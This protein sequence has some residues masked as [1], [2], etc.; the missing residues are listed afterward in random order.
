MKIKYMLFLSLIVFFTACQ[1]SLKTHENSKLKIL[2]DTDA[3]NELDDQ[4][5]MAYAFLNQE[6]F[7]V[8]G[9]TVNNTRNGYG[10]QGQY[11]EAER[12]VQ[13]FDL[14]NKVPLFMGADKSYAEIA[15]A[16]QQNN[17]DGQAAVNFIISEALK[18]KDEKLILVP[19]GKLTNIALAFLKEPKIIEKVRVVWLGS[20]YP[21]PG[22]YNLVNDTTAVNPVIESGVELEMVTVRYG[23]PSGTDAV[24]VT[25]E[26]VATHLAGKGPVSKNTIIGRHGGEFNSFG[27]Y[28]KDLYAHAKMHGNRPSRALFDMVTLAI[29]KNENWG[30]KKNIPAPKLVGDAWEEKPENTNR[31]YIWE[32]FNRDAIVNDFF[33]LME[34]ST[35]N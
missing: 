13:L 19:I 11:D 18:M 31:I 9:I 24:R 4:H 33:D 29:L 12:I 26:E 1:N 20:N 21:N 10:I 34:Q 2:I 32:N 7:N 15:P 27:D 23:K 28:S 22:E 8:V 35:P 30:E 14:E 3:N 6:I 16:I 17:F 25:P 5:A